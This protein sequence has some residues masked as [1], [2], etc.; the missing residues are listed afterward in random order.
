MSC[1]KKK[2][3]WSICYLNVSVIRH[4]KNLR[5]HKHHSSVLYCNS[6]KENHTKPRKGWKLKGWKN[7]GVLLCVSLSEG[8]F[9]RELLIQR[10]INCSW[11]LNQV[12]S[13]RAWVLALVLLLAHQGL[14]LIHRAIRHGDIWCPNNTLQL[15]V[16]PK[17]VGFVSRGPGW[18]Q[19]CLP[20]FHI[21]LWPKVFCAHLSWNLLKQCP[22][23]LFFFSFL[24]AWGW[25]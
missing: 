6:A 13:F 7:T 4:T 24:W 5:K 14:H 20:S 15:N 18:E 25:V 9:K 21:L 11:T 19:K 10:K 8:H 3:T 12:S 17:Y 16:L 22:E 23:L 1:G 2:K